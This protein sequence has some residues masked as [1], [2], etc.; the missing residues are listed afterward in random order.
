[1]RQTAECVGLALAKGCYNKRHPLYH[2]RFLSAGIRGFRQEISLEQPE[3]SVKQNEEQKI[4]IDETFTNVGFFLCCSLLLSGSN[5]ATVVRMN[6]KA[7]CVRQRFTN[8]QTGRQT[9]L[10]HLEALLLRNELK[11]RPASNRIP[12]IYE[13]FQLYISVRPR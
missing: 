5:K 11:Q 13:L 6:R 2:E 7:L 12:R 9:R 10:A 4:K 1:M 8:F 3:K